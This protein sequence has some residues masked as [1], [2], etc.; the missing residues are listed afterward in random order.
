MTYIAHA[1]RI[2]AAA[3]FAIPRGPAA[4]VSTSAQ[5]APVLT[6]RHMNKGASLKVFNPAGAVR[7]V[8]DLGAL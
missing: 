7:L 2:A 3:A 1:L 8:G 4:A 6:A 5:T